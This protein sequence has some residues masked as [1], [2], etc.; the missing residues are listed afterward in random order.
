M[1]MGKL[2]QDANHAETVNDQNLAQ[3]FGWRAVFF[4]FLS[5]ISVVIL[6]KKAYL[7]MMKGCVNRR[8][9]EW[10]AG[11][12]FMFELQKPMS[13]FRYQ[14]ASTVGLKQ[15]PSR[16]TLSDRAAVII[17]LLQDKQSRCQMPASTLL[18]CFFSFFL[19]IF[20]V[21][22]QG[23]KR[24]YMNVLE[25]TP[26]LPSSLLRISSMHAAWI[27]AVNHSWAAHLPSGGPTLNICQRTQG[28]LHKW[29]HCSTVLK[30]K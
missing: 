15:A 24:P 27:P 21:L 16:W 12:A 18:F 6:R 17:S 29:W 13:H 22:Q 14:L 5:L 10:H 8:R 7:K 11:R 19:F 3:K 4:F 30:N 1:C 28:L 23:Y 9:E 26:F 25:C 20:L 2:L